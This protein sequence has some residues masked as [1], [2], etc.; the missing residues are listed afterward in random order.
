MQPRGLGMPPT[1]AASLAGPLGNSWYSSLMGT[2]DAL[3]SVRID[4]A[5]PVL[6]VGGA[7]E[8]DD[9]P[10]TIGQCVDAVGLGNLDRNLGASTTPGSSRN[11]SASTPTTVSAMVAVGMSGLRW[12][13]GDSTGCLPAIDIWLGM[14]GTSR[15]G[16]S[17]CQ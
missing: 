6:E 12:W 16:S 7:H 8:V 11:P 15:P 3:P 17:R 2:P 4:G 10:V 13:C 9:L 1:L 5:V 14:P